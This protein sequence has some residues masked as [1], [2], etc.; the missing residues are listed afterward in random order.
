M[1]QVTL[2]IPDKEYEFFIQL[3]KKFNEVKIKEADFL[4]PEKHKELV[5]DRRRTAK[6][7]DFIDWNVAKKSLGL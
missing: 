7:S 6:K 2:Q 5:R 1:K 3:L 4:I